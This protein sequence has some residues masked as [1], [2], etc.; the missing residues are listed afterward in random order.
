MDLKGR[1]VLVTGADGFIGS[2]LVEALARE[3]AIVRAFCYYN[4]WGRQGW[5]EAPFLDPE[6][7][8]EIEAFPGDIRDP[9]RVRQAVEGCEVVFHLS[10]L[11]AIPYSYHAPASYVQTNVLG[12]LHVLEACRDVGVARLVHTSTSE[13]YGTARRVPIDESHPL[14]GQSPYSA[15]KIAADVLVE[16]FH[17]SFGVPAVTVRPFNTY[18]PRQSPRAV[19]PAILGQLLA[20]LPELRLGALHPTRDFVFVED[21]V[22]GFLA[23]ARRDGIEGEVIQLASGRE[24]SIGHLAEQC[25]EVVGRRVPV[26]TEGVRLRPAES[27]VERLVG[28]ASKARN[29]LDWN[30][31]VTLEE[32]LV[33]TADFLRRHPPSQRPDRFAY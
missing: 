6:I 33:C 9:G 26:I 19:I 21:T 27:E 30:P 3:G 14:Q 17:R 29:L 4:S 2:H 7:L 13:V 28:D 15:S 20:G 24:I 11:I 10:S 22:A 32:G 1:R 12:A 16:S 5:L 31:R 18:G 25:M 8:R 23:A